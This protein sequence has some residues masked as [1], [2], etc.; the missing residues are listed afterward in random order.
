[1]GAAPESASA[2]L[3][4]AVEVPIPASAPAEKFRLLTARVVLLAVSVAPARFSVPSAIYEGPV[5]VS[6]PP[7]SVKLSSPAKKND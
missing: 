4:V 5:N 2:P 1:M 6:E 7:L 3:T